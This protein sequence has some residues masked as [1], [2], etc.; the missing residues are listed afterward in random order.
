MVEHSLAEVLHPQSIAVV[1]ASDDGRGSQYFSTLIEFG[2]KGSIYPVNPKYATVG[3]MKAYPTVKDIPGPVDFVISAA[4]APQIPKI[5]QDCADK[6]VKGIHLFTAR[7]SETGRQDAT[8]LEK[9]I[10]RIAKAGGVRI[11]GPNCMGVYLP[12]V[13]VSWQPSFPKESG[14]I[15]LASQSGQAA[16]EIINKTTTSGALFNKA[17]SYGNA[18]DFNEC[19]FLQY[20]GD[21]PEV[22]IIM[23]YIE[24]PKN[25]S[26]F[27]N[28]LRE[29]TKKKPVVIIKGGRGRS[30]SRAVSSH[31][32]SLAGSSEIWNTAIR[33]SGA[34]SV[35][36]V[37]ELVDVAV[38]F[39]F[40]S[41][42]TG[43]RVGV[44]AGA[45]GAT[46]LASDQCEEAGLDVIPLPQEIREDLKRQGIQIWDWINNPADFSISMGDN[47]FNSQQLLKMMAMHPSFDLIISSVMIPGGMPPHPVPASSQGVG[48]PPILGTPSGPSGG[49]PNFGRPGGGPPFGRPGPGGGG[50][51]G[52]MGMSLDEVVDQYKQINDYKPLLGIIQDRSPDARDV[53]DPREELRWKNTC[54][55]TTKF[56][57]LKIPYFPSVERAAIAASKVIGYYQMRQLQKA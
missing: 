32:A 39:Y 40:L 34:V 46:V 30:G 1:G 49:P 12:K 27:F 5:M 52:M 10:L 25:G 23:M 16:G 48:G 18:I 50:P 13:G 2:F 44:A 37:D 57:A 28:L 38:S 47:D 8:E 51:P 4:P 14:S 29:V 11:I 36:S 55:A 6:G 45:G 7:F 53:D 35:N 56:I 42:I 41:P 22:K 24:G 20:F 31:T 33:Q 26:R 21:D 54:L 43:R 17:I 15:A 19:D 9:Q 3:N